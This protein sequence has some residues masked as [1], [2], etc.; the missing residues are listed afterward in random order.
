M[1]ETIEQ[2]GAEEHGGR[3]QKLTG[4]V[5]SNK[6]DKTIIVKVERTIMH[7]LYQRYVKSSKRYAAHD[8]ENTCR[9]GDLVEII[10]SRPLSKT[11]RWR[12]NEVLQ[13][14]EGV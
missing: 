6:G 12:L 2:N 11:K 14:A 9:E 1:S 5:V 3:R 4:T 7:K 8:E 10:Q 13:R